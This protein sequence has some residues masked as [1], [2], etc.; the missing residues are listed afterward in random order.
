MKHLECLVIGNSPLTLKC[1]ESL[2]YA[3]QNI[4]AVI[5]DS[6][7]VISWCLSNNINQYEAIP[8]NL[9]LNK[10]H[11]IFVDQPAIPLVKKT[12]FA[13]IENLSLN[14]SQID[15]LDFSLPA[16][17]ATTWSLSF[18]NKS[19]TH[20]TEVLIDKEL[21]LGQFSD[22]KDRLNF[23]T[24]EEVIIAC[25]RDDYTFLY[26]PEKTIEAKSLQLNLAQ[27]EVA[28]LPPNDVKNYLL[29]AV[30][31]VFI[32][33][34]LNLTNIVFYNLSDSFIPKLGLDA[35]AL[36]SYQTRRLNRSLTLRKVLSDFISVRDKNYKNFYFP[37]E[38]ALSTEEKQP[39]N[40]GTNIVKII[41]NHWN[42]DAT[43]RVT[44]FYTR[45]SFI[46]K[47]LLKALDQFISQVG[48]NLDQKISDIKILDFEE[49]SNIFKQLNPNYAPY[50]EKQHYLTLF[51]NS[52]KKFPKN[53]A[54]ETENVSLNY[55]QLNEKTDKIAQSIRVHL[56]NRTQERIAIVL[57]KGLDFYFAVF[58]VFKSQCIYI[59]IDTE[60]PFERITYILKDSKCSLII[61]NEHIKSILSKSNTSIDIAT[62][63]TLDLSKDIN[64]ALHSCSQS[65]P[66]EGFSYM[67][68]TSG[69]TGE[70]KGVLISSSSLA[71]L[72]RT[73]IENFSITNQSRVLQ[74]S[75]TSFDASVLEFSIALAAGATLIIPKEKKLIG[76][77]L[78][79]FIDAKRIS[80]VHLPPTVLNSLKPRSFSTL[81][82]VVGGGEACPSKLVSDWLPY[83]TLYNSYGPTENTVCATLFKC[84]SN[85]PSTTIGHPLK[86]VKAYIVNDQ[87]ELLPQGIPGELILSG[88]GVCGGYFGKDTLTKGKFLLSRN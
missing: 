78:L 22:I 15:R 8:S 37:T 16:K 56:Q 7:D 2:F 49:K 40:N 47:P 69:S 67:I 14:N 13:V 12:A 10:Y 27:C 85:Y 76:E 38:I 31:E 53:I 63:G 52:V 36:G 54:L 43:G 26:K 70:P 34:Y 21:L 18:K 87:L 82:K 58:S 80:F 65:L 42:F 68:Y 30:C 19:L 20:T 29:R 62:I 71:C 44:V 81:K 60:L 72:A 64:I 6:S 61:T 24:F 3:G 57:P 33:K 35:I 50:S 79:S 66:P 28:E 86:H 75:S 17:L 41:N 77:A 39:E 5:S 23:N 51:N 59:P 55:K 45:N 88:Q 84:K 1:I 25:S 32:A 83:I 4:V 11:C 9:L 48:K 73:Q 46:W 74:F